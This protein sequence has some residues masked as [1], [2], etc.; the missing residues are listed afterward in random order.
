MY[1][2]T[3][4]AR[5]VSDT[6]ARM[7]FLVDALG[8]LAF[9]VLY[10]VVCTR[11]IPVNVGPRVHNDDDDDD[12]ADCCARARYRRGR[13]PSGASRRASSSGRS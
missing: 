6:C 4:R 9:L 1:F 5:A 10:T 3:R 8:L 11:R 13:S 12:N 7:Q 2:G